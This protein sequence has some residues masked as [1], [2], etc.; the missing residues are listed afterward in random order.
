MGWTTGVKFLARATEEERFSL[1]HLVHIG[2]PPSSAEVK[3]AW[4]YNSAPLFVFM[5]WC[6][7]KHRMRFHGMVLS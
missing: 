1:Y 3:N 2:S 7:I 5:A 6:L 4:T